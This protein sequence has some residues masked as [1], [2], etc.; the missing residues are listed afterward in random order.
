[1]PHNTKASDSVSEIMRNAAQYEIMR[2][3]YK[4]IPIVIRLEFQF[5][6]LSHPN[7]RIGRF[8]IPIPNPEAQYL[9]LNGVLI[10]SSSELLTDSIIFFI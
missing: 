7:S 1:M 3:R 8:I 4:P 10:N 2:R 5:Q 6:I 9:H